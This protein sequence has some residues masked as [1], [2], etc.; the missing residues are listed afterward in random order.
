MTAA[1]GPA[2]GGAHELDAPD[3][4][5]VALAA[6][7][8]DVTRRDQ[9]QAAVDRDV[10]IARLVGA[11]WVEIGGRLGTTRQGALKR[12]GAWVAASQRALAVARAQVD[13]A[14]PSSPVAGPAVDVPLDLG[15]GDVDA[16][17]HALGR[18]LAA[19]RGE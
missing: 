13:Q 17:L 4:I 8:G 5:R 14:Q 10:E 3:P 16:A 1:E 19:Q 6:L 2:E 7:M 9:A 15:A 12:Y 11:S 18:A